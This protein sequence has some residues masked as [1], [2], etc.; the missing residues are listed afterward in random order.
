MATER[1]TLLSQQRT[2][3]VEQLRQRQVIERQRRLT[4]KEATLRSAMAELLHKARSEDAARMQQVRQELEAATQ[5]YNHIAEQQAELKVRLEGLD[6]ELT[7]SSR[8][9]ETLEAERQTSLAR[10]EQAFHGSNPGLD[11]EAIAWLGKAAQSVPAELATDLGLLQSRLT[12]LAQQERQLQEQRRVLRERQLALQLSQELEAQY[13]RARLKQQ[14]EQEARTSKAAELLAK[15]RSSADRGKFDEALGWIAQ[16]QAMNPP[17]LSQVTAFREELLQERE[18]AVRE[19]QAAQIER[20]FARAKAV[21]E[22]G[23]YEEAVQLF[24]KVIEEEAALGVSG[25]PSR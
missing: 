3:F 5:R 16:A 11:L 1:D 9:L 17:Q 13:E 6:H 7:A 10:L 12:A 18:R 21:Y 15:A 23:K 22:Q 24:G 8:R 19:A 20:L 4:L 25:Q 14:Q 2:T